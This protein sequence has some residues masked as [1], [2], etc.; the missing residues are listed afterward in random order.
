MKIKKYD[1]QN[2]SDLMHDL[3]ILMNNKVFKL[4]YNKYFTNWMNINTMIMYIK[5]YE[6]IEIS[7][8][9][10]FNRKIKKNEILFIL[11]NIIKNPL[12]RQIVVNNYNIYKN[13]HT[14]HLLSYNLQLTN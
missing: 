9:K 6:I 8:L 14:Q 13:S 11:N 7:F 4:F 12:L 3:Y 10:K 5:L 2:K 1:I